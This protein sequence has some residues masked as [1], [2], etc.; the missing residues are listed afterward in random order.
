M[1]RTLLGRLSF[2]PYGLI[3]KA[4]PFL[5]FQ[6]N[7]TTT[8]LFCLNC[9]FFNLTIFVLFVSSAAVLQFLHDLMAKNIAP[10]S[11]QVIAFSLFVFD[12]FIIF[13]KT[14]IGNAFCFHCLPS[15]LQ[16]PL[17]CSYK[18]KHVLPSMSNLGSDRLSAWKACATY[19]RVAQTV[20][21]TNSSFFVEEEIASCI[22]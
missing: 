19:E 6:S 10:I 9:M 17:S 13:L 14:I 16:Y 1:E 12:K 7:T 21:S 4:Y 2:S 8:L 20:P 3:C 5:D 18:I 22:A 11:S 15:S